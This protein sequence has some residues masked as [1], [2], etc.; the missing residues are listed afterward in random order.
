MPDHVTSQTGSH[1][2]GLVVLAVP[3]L[4]KELGVG[5]QAARLHLQQASC[6]VTLLHQLLQICLDMHRIALGRL[7][8]SFHLRREVDGGIGERGA[9]DHALLELPGF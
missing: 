3:P 2:G 6:I 5:L 1:R 8:T 7:W 4:V 9:A